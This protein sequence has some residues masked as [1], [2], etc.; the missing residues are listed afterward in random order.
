[1]PSARSTWTG[2]ALA[3]D[4]ASPEKF[5]I[6]GGDAL[7]LWSHQRA[8]VLARA[9]GGRELSLMDLAAAANRAHGADRGRRS[10][11][12]VDPDITAAEPMGRA[13]GPLIRAPLDVGCRF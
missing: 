3:F 8:I 6:R 4:S 10:S 13:R 2:R 1:L 11:N 9:R 7:D 5:D 12:G